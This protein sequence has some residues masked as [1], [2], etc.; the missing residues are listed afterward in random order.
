MQFGVMYFE[1]W[2]S[3]WP[4]VAF[5][6]LVFCSCVFVFGGTHM[7]PN[8]LTLLEPVSCL[9]SSLFSWLVDGA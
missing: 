9:E 3:T 4:Y 7:A 6:T 8:S 1:T 5:C 2:H